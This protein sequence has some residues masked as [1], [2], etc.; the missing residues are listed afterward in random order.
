MPPPTEISKIIIQYHN[1][2]WINFNNLC[3]IN[4]Y[5][6]KTIYQNWRKKK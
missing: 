4:E 1:F 5:I 2:I 3:Y 6:E